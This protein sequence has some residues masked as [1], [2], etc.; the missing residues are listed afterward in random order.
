M[1]SWLSI[2]V[3]VA[4]VVWASHSEGQ[5]KPADYVLS[6]TLQK[7]ADAIHREHPKARL[8]QVAIVDFVPAAIG[9]D[10]SASLSIDSGF[11]SEDNVRYYAVLGRFS[12][13]DGSQSSS[14]RISL[15]TFRT[16][17]CKPRYAE[18][19]STKSCG[20][21]LD[22]PESE[23]LHH[24]LEVPV[25][26]LS[27]IFDILREKGFQLSYRYDLQITTAARMVSKAEEF[28]IP[29][30]SKLALSRFGSTKPDAAVVLIRG[31]E[32]KSG[33][34]A[35]TFALVDAQTPSI[36]DIGHSTTL[37]LLP[38]TRPH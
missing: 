12:A 17:P 36:I 33:G 20:G 9:V 25:T 18:E 22:D 30:N 6:T 31:R 7:E 21:P 11:A 29:A 5:D 24:S 26:S 37:N 1:R 14:P 13:C 35:I 15:R 3:A 19:E 4:M 27:K 38:P 23:E 10:C 28:E 2:S 32:S 16:V 34:G 8:F